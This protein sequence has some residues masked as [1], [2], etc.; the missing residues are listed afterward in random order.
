[1]TGISAPPSDRSAWRASELAVTVQTTPGTQTPYLDNE[2]AEN[3]WEKTATLASEVP[4]VAVII[5]TLEEGNTVLK[6]ISQIQDAT[7][8]ARVVV[9]DGGSSDGTLDQAERASV[10]VIIDKRKGYGRAIRTGIENVNA[11]VYAMVDADDTYDL[12]NFPQMLNIAREGRLVIGARMKANDDSMALSH[13]IGNIV[14]SLVH[15]VLFR[16]KVL[17]TQSGFKIFPAKIARFLRENG[18]TLSSEILVLANA[19]N[20]PTVEVPVKYHPRHCESRSKFSFWRDGIRVLSFL[21]RS[22]W[23]IKGASLS[24]ESD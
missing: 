20:I 6:V 8:D 22:K 21:I 18:M 10:L 5:P 23:T 19:L 12:S 4:S 1:M 16:G 9:V 13:T 14:L 2:I 7:P 11:D 24:N 3:R 15:R 17:D